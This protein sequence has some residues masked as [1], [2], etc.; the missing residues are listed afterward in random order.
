M[1]NKRVHTE[2]T[3]HK[4]VLYWF[5]YRSWGR[6]SRKL[7]VPV[8]TLRAWSRMQWWQDSIAE[9][10]EKYQKKLDSQYTH[11]LDKVAESILDRL[12]NG[13]ERVTASGKVVRVGVGA[14]DLATL[15]RDVQ[16]NRALIRGEPTQRRETVNT[17]KTLDKVQDFFEKE[18][19]DVQ[20]AKSN[21]KPYSSYLTDEESVH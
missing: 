2:E 17:E 18:H 4:A 9:I 15:L 3:R 16:S 7:G 20:P 1:P 6:V 8:S 19:P 21:R 14:R 13:E 11:I 12:R 5:A 10:R